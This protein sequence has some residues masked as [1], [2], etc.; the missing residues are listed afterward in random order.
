MREPRTWTCRRGS[1]SSGEMDGVAAAVMASPCG[2]P[3]EKVAIV[4]PPR[5]WRGVR[6]DRGVRALDRFAVQPIRQGGGELL[7]YAHVANAASQESVR[8]R[9]REQLEPTRIRALAAFA[10]AA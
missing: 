10:P 2:S 6:G 8:E 4:S 9:D 7:R 3:R 5:G 1:G